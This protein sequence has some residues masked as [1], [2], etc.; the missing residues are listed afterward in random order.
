MALLLWFSLIGYWP[1]APQSFINCVLDCNQVADSKTLYKGLF[2]YV[3]L[4]SPTEEWGL[5]LLTKAYMW[6]WRLKNYFPPRANERR[7]REG[8]G[9]KG[10][11]KEGS[12]GNR[13]RSTTWG[14]LTFPM[15]L[16]PIPPWTK[17]ILCPSVS[18]SGF[19]MIKRT[20]FLSLL[21]SV[22]RDVRKQWF[23]NWI[24][25]IY[26]VSIP[27]QSSFCENLCCSSCYLLWLK[28]TW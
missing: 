9:R 22:N 8:K 17:W 11:V 24:V 16:C 14:M 18:L 20:V 27:L 3:I 19:K 10:K 15:S 13:S 28:W 2:C 25:A 5:I 1:V 23:P 6:V 26:T 4:G 12:S 7:T 21:R